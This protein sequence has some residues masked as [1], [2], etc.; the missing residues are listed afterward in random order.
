MYHLRLR[1]AMQFWMINIFNKQVDNKKVWMKDN[2][3]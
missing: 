3:N 2:V 1:N